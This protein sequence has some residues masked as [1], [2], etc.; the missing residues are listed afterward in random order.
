MT[1]QLDLP[2]VSLNPALVAAVLDCLPQ[3][4]PAQRSEPR[5]FLH[6]ASA[7]G[8]APREAAS[9]LVRLRAAETLMGDVRWQQWRRYFKQ[10]DRVSRLRF[11]ALLMQLIASAPLDERAN[12]DADIFFSQLLAGVF[13]AARD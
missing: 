8:A 9:L 1:A 12:F 2:T 10:A 4:T 11:D 6:I 5:V 7:L 13:V 3:L